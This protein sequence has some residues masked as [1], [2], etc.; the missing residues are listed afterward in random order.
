MFAIVEER[1]LGGI[2]LAHGMTKI[3][4]PDSSPDAALHK[5]CRASRI[6]LRQ[7]QGER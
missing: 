2:V 3:P 6:A 4:P 7:A 1:D 5:K